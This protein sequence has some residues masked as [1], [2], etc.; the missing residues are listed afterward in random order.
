MTAQPPIYLRLNPADNV[1][2][3]RTDILPGTAVEKV[4]TTGTVPAGHKI[5]TVPIKQGEP[6]RKYDQ[7]IGFASQDIQPG[8]HIHVDNC[9]MGDF[10][11]DYAIGVDAREEGLLSPG[12]GAAG[13][14]VITRHGGR[15]PSRARRD[16]SRP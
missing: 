12:H 9:A 2:V 13:G 11:R 14:A 16:G 1:V 10:D 7:I 15:T 6:V 3:A 5:A 8:D 4:T